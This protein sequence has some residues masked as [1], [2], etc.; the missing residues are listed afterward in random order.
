M[1]L[2]D[3]KSVASDMETGDG[4]LWPTPIVYIMPADEIL[5]KA[6]GPVAASRS[7]IPM[8]KGNAVIAM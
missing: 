5:Q 4:P 7:R 2:T 6:R 3:T 1:N 8:S